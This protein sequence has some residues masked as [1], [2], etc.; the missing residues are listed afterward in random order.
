M[1]SIPEDLFDHLLS[2][3]HSNLFPVF[4]LS[5][6][7]L[8]CTHPPLKTHPAA[9]TV[10]APELTCTEAAC[11]VSLNGKGSSLAAFQ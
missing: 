4:A 9:H 8:Q 6:A 10:H 5:S 1:S 11:N 2:V 7:H 3:T